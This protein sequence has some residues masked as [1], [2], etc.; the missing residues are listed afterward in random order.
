MNK[1]TQE[2]VME[3][4]AMKPYVHRITMKNRVY[5]PT[6][7]NAPDSARS[8]VAYYNDGGLFPRRIS[9]DKKFS[10]NANEGKGGFE[11]ISPVKNET[12]Y[13]WMRKP[14]TPSSQDSD[15]ENSI[16]SAQASMNARRSPDTQLASN[17][18]PGWVQKTRS[19]AKPAAPNIASSL[20]SRFGGGR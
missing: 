16:A 6:G 13:P 19:I 17:S 18:S 10:Y 11:N 4:L 7:T 8:D 12:M 9:Q 2:F 5:D 15:F 14:S 3:K 1:I 20:S